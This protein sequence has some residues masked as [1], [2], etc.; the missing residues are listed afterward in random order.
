[1]ILDIII[2]TEDYTASKRLLMN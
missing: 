2:H 1:M